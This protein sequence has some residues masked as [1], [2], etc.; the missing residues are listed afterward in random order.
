M[1]DMLNVGIIGTGGITDGHIKNLLAT[2]RARIAALCDP[3]S[4]NRAAR[5]M[6]HPIGDAREFDDYRDMLAAGGLD[7]AVVA[8]PHTVH[9]EQIVACLE[10]GLHVLAQKPMVVSVDEAVRVI[11][12]KN[13]AGKVVLVSY[14]RHYSQKYRYI[15]KVAEAGELGRIEYIQAVQLQEW[16]LIVTEWCAWRGDPKHAGYGQLSDS[17]SHLM[18]ILLW[19]TGEKPD[20][21]WANWDRCGLDV[22]VNTSMM[23]RTQNGAL[24]SIAIIGNAPRCSEN[25]AVVGDVGGVFL[26]GGRLVHQ[27]SPY[28]ESREINDTP[29]PWWRA[30][31]PSLSSPD[32]NFVA[33]A[34][35]GAENES[36][37][38]GALAVTALTEAVAESAAAGGKPVKVKWPEF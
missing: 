11:E 3:R 1:A 2:G 17:G 35:D 7:A 5:K 12:A 33:A 6:A 9:C 37:A 22:D 18:D 32:A 30:S 20:T 27:V 23:F 31:P 26:E 38:E 29:A 4:E 14:Q 13:K 28:D 24:G 19:A 21:V 34:L 15:K 8:S 16:K 25:L 10:A 36:T